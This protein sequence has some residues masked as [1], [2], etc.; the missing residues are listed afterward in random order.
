MLV[1]SPRQSGEGRAHPS[2]SQLK[3][4]AV[5]LQHEERGEQ[6]PG[7]NQIRKKRLKA[8][9]LNSEQMSEGAL[10]REGLVFHGEWIR[11]SLSRLPQ[12]P[13]REQ[14]PSLLLCCRGRGGEGHR[15]Y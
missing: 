1:S 6:T 2:S 12:S 7:V 8:K 5:H 14:G 9:G 10:G 4:L 3:P 11:D 15:H 13:Q